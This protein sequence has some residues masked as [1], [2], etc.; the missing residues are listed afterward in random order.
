MRCPAAATCGHPARPAR[1]RVGC[2]GEQIILDTGD[3]LDLL[4][5]FF[6]SL[7]A[8]SAKFDVLPVLPI[9]P[10]H[11]NDDNR[12]AQHHKKI[13]GR[14][15]KGSPDSHVLRGC[16]HAVAVAPPPS[17]FRQAGRNKGEGS[18][19]SVRRGFYLNTKAAPT[20]SQCGLMPA[21]LTSSRFCLIWARKNAS[22]SAAVMSNGS[23]PR[24]VSLS[25]TAF[26]CSA[27]VASR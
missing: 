26:T 9:Q 22:N 13:L 11:T 1:G 8:M 23:P 7:D 4:G 27:L 24:A 18:T 20:S 5:T 21:A 12:A 16:K 3:T 2:Q 6:V 17:R 10:C 15:K 19:P 14:S 25:C